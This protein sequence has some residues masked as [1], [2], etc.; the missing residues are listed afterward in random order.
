MQ[1]ELYI[2][3]GISLRCLQNISTRALGLA[4]PGVL[5][6]GLVSHSCWCTAYRMPILPPS[7]LPQCIMPCFLKFKLYINV[8]HLHPGDPLFILLHTYIT[9][10]AGHHET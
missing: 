6:I 5:V 10:G 3:S 7:Q 2:L 8:K 9:R 4:G 1:R